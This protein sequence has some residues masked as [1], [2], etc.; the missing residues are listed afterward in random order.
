MN[1]SRSGYYASINRPTK[2]IIEFEL[3]LHLSTKA[4]FRESR[5]SRQLMKRLRK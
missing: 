2:I 1:V 3:M 4:V 5:D